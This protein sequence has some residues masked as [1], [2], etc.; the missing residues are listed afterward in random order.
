LTHEP[1]WAASK[2]GYRFKTARKI[3]V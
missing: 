3:K 1:A 2:S